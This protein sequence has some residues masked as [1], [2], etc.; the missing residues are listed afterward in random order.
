MTW[1]NAGCES[2]FS[3]R[4]AIMASDEPWIVWSSLI[5]AVCM[6]DGVCMIGEEGERGMSDA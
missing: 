3:G 6:I 5:D 1:T 2:R 4:R